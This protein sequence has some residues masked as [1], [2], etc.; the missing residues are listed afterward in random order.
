MSFRDELGLTNRFEIRDSK[1]RNNDRHPVALHCGLRG[2]A[3][4]LSKRWGVKQ[5][6]EFFTEIVENWR[7]EGF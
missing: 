5:P 1:S 2:G 3:P 7:N 4:E 6:G